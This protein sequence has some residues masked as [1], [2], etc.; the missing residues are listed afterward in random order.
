MFHYLGMC[1]Y[2]ALW[3]VCTYPHLQKSSPAGQI[4][5]AGFLVERYTG[6]T[7][8]NCDDLSP[9][10]GSFNKPYTCIR[11]IHSGLSSPR[12][13]GYNSLKTEKANFTSRHDVISEMT[14]I[15]PGPELLS[16]RNVDKVRTE[17]PD[18]C[19]VSRCCCGQAGASL[20]VHCGPHWPH[21]LFFRESLHSW[22]LSQERQGEGGMLPAVFRRVTKL[23]T[24]LTYVLVHANEVHSAS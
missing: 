6:I 10:S 3:H 13:M 2:S 20:P 1:S 23:V 17:W 24:V 22:R 8:G 14:G 7:L 16:R 4:Q 19:L 21:F 9:T 12:T 18:N 15:S 5:S 11:C